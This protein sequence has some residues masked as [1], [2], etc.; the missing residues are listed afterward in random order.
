M[1]E[2]PPQ[3]QPQRP[4]ER[5]PERSTDDTTYT[6]SVQQR[7]G[8]ASQSSAQAPRRPSSA[9]P[10][11]AP[12]QYAPPPSAYNRRPTRKSESGWYLPWWSLLIMVGVVGTVAISLLFALS[13]L[14][15]PQT[16]GNQTPRVRVVTSQPTLSQDFAAGGALQNTNPTSIPQALPTATVPLPTPV[17][18]PSLPPGEFAI[19]ASVTVVG[20]GSSGLN[21]RSTPGLEGSPRF[22]AYDEEIFMLVDGPQTADDLEWWRIED[23][24]DA[25]RYGWAARNFLTVTSP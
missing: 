15:E 25:N 24:N 1:S 3:D 10:V 2:I 17:P 11:P 9:R 4:V 8:R 21:I 6:R 19:G 5:Q 12:D 20:V 18:S 22:L 14:I 23:P 13:G 16:P 7:T